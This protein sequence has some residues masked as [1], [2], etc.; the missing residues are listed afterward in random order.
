VSG[1]TLLPPVRLFRLNW[2]NRKAVIW[3][4][5]LFTKSALLT[6][7]IWLGLF[8]LSIIVLGSPEPVSVATMDVVA[9]ML[10]RVVFMEEQVGLWMAIFILNTIVA[11]FAS[12]AGA[13]LILTLP[14]EA[15]DIR[16]RYTHPTYARAS[17]QLDRY[18][19]WLLWKNLITLFQR[20]DTFAK[21]YKTNT[22]Q[23]TPLGFWK[24]IGY[25]RSDFQ[26]M[27]YILP[28]LIPALTAIV[29]G[30]VFGMVLTVTII[31]GAYEG[32]LIGGGTGFMNGIAQQSLH[33]LA[34]T[35]PHGVLELS[36][37]FS[38]IAL[39]HSFADQFTRELISQ[40]L[41]IDH[42]IEVFE[43]NISYLV[44]FSKQ[45][46]ISKTMLFTLLLFSCVLFVAAYIEVYI[47][48]VIAESVVT[49]SY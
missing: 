14:F 9:I 28:F 33:F 16:Y 11:V 45:F 43:K 40:R 22:S 13:L 36:V 42:R 18:G 6:S 25:S 38:A 32:F 30:I 4:V 17:K 31:Q 37:I 1:N 29:N 46:L 41:L 12:I 35:M 47:T 15:T 19:Y 34:F 2:I 44:T 39:G 26:R 23:N 10:Q 7:G 24:L 21:Q 48:P 27:F 5:K 3:T 20:F 49:I 8:T